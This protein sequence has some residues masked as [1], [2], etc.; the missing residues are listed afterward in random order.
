MTYQALTTAITGLRAA[1][2]Q[3]SVISNNVTNATTP[4]YNRQVLPQA[5][6]PTITNFL[7]IA[8]IITFVNQITNYSSKCLKELQ[9]FS[10]PD[11]HLND[12]TSARTSRN[13]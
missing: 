2:Q 3:L 1:Q 5:P 6:S 4:G 13:R 9:Y 10:L 7:R 8:A 12:R 11:I